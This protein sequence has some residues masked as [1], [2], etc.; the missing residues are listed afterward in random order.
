MKFVV[1]FL[2]ARSSTGM[3]SS[4][5]LRTP[6]AVASIVALS[7]LTTTRFRILMTSKS[8]LLTRKRTK[9]GT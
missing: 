9:D 2:R 8:K 5:R 6:V 4:L 1:P 3:V 7:R